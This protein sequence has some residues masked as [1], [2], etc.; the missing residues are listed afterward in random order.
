LVSSVENLLSSRLLSK[1][2]KV[3]ICKI[4]IFLVVL[5]GCGTSSLTLRDEHRLRGGGVENRVLRG[6]FGPKRDEV[7]GGSCSEIQ[8]EIDH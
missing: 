7:T 1:N 4:L 6:L 8:K 5:Y 2:V 3:K